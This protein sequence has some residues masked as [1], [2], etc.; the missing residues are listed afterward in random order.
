[1]SVY[2]HSRLSTFENCPLAFKLHYIDRIKREE[3]GVE[4]FVGSRFH[5]TMEVLYKELKFKTCTL[6][7][8][9]DFYKNKWDKEWHKAVIIT[10]KD[11]TKAD[12]YNLGKKCIEDY[13]NHYC[14]FDGS[15]VL[16]L[17]RVINIQLDKEGKYKVTGYADRI[18][19]DKN[20]TYE[21]HDYKTSGFLP[22]QKHFDEDRQL[23]FYHIGIQNIWN[24]VKR[25]KLIWHYV[26][27][28]KEM[29]STRKDEEL[30]KL[31][32]D[33]IVLID[34]IESTKEF[35][36]QESGLCEW[37]VYPD[38]CPKRK[39]LYKVEAMPVNEY[40]ND[41]G[42][43]LVNAYTELAEKKRS[44]ED[45]IDEID[46]ELDK[47]KEAAIKY[48]EKESADVI[49]GSDHKLKITEK[50]KISSPPKGSDERKELEKI[51]R[52]SGKWDEISDLDARA[53][54]K[55]ISEERWDKKI[56]DKIK[57]FLTIEV[58]ISVTLSKLQDKEK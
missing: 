1:M 30:E 22:S 2:S 34:K 26:V 33:T 10:R 27:F 8:L 56:V 48:S 41:S 35:L 52:D 18:A 44:L 28:D 57:K 16:G 58:K 53:M 39:H 49:R 7:D 32:E 25:V 19:Q 31:K 20:G 45:K 15:K 11:R 23:A 4:A 37:C 14:P 43:K 17:E 3:E 42:V 36:P 55:A 13:Y 50:Q 38:L 29:I 6:K 21:I 9:L 5:E 40:L 51:L 24:D 12:Y 54:E 46:V 47:I